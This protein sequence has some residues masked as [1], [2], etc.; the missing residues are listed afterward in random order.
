MS[1]EEYYMCKLELDKE[2]Y[3]EKL[4][5]EFANKKPKIIDEASHWK[6]FEHSA[7][8][9]AAS[10]TM[11]IISIGEQEGLEA[12]VAAL[13]TVAATVR[14]TSALAVVSGAKAINFFRSLFDEN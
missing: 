1:E 8:V 13:T 10:G 12:G 9:A 6:E 7:G 2:Y 11:A 4:K 14:A 3:R 5:L